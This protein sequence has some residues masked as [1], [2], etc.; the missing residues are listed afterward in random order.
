MLRLPVVQGFLSHILYLFPV[1]RRISILELFGLHSEVIFQS[2]SIC[3]FFFCYCICIFL[4]RFIAYNLPSHAHSFKMSDNASS[5]TLSEMDRVQAV[6][7]GGFARMER[8][9]SSHPS[10]ENL[11]RIRRLIGMYCYY[12]QELGAALDYCDDRL[13]LLIMADSY[14]HSEQ[15]RNR[16]RLAF[17]AAV[18][19]EKIR[20]ARAIISRRRNKI[21]R[22]ATWLQFA[23]QPREFRANT[24][25][26]IQRT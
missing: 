16:R 14:I 9:L 23:N 8:S 2:P 10:P 5:F 21:A 1:V 19:E 11:S 26:D 22:L 12:I 6:T 20:A 15:E 18:R 17:Q 7:P 25:R 24:P 13:V 3:Y 4:N